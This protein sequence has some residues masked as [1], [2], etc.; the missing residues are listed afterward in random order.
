MKIGII[1]LIAVTFSLSVAQNVSEKLYVKGE[2]IYLYKCDTKMVDS[3]KVE[4]KTE[5]EELITQKK[6][7]QNLNDKELNALSSYLWDI[8]LGNASQ[9][10]PIVVPK[11]AKCPIC[12]M[13][14]AKYPHWVASIE[15]EHNHYFD[16]VKDMMKFIFQNPKALKH[17]IK[18]TN[19]FTFGALDARDAWYVIGSNVYG[20]MGNELIPF[21]SQSEAEKFK[22]RHFGT[23]IVRFN[24]IDSTIINGLD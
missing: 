24:E 11:K 17:T 13:F 5:L 21:G 15:G 7:C 20:P 19:Y 23:K 10:A 1:V 18:V 16:G 3:L 12:G 9:S 22:E 8:K 2:K 4:S 6:S 14:V